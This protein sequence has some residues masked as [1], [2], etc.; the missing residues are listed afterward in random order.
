MRIY[1]TSRNRTLS[2][3]SPSDFQFALERPIELPEGARGIIDSFTCSNVWESVLAGVNQKVYYQYDYMSQQTVE[4]EPGDL[5]NVGALAT[6]L[7]TA[8]QFESPLEPAVTVTASGN[9]LLFACPG[10]G[11]GQR[12]TL[13]SRQTLNSGLSAYT[14]P[15]GGWA[16]ASALVGAM[17]KDIKII[18]AADAGSLTPAQVIDLRTSQMVNLSPYQTLYLHSH[19][20]D[21]DSY[22]PEGSSTVIASI[23]TGSTVP[24]DIITHHHNG[25]L[26]SPIQLPPLLGMMHFSLRS[27]DGKVIDTDGHD[28]ALT[29]VCET[30]R[31]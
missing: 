23:T 27:Y 22:G 10:L 12:F 21:N 7:T 9:R 25:L 26:A 2:S 11:V 8:I 31:E 3:A 1:I 18:H 29:L 30:T 28:L 17:T 24:G 4:L 16:D 5:I 13:F 20:G 19:I 15:A 6:K 14:R